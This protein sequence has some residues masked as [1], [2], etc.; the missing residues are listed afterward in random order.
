MA[1]LTGREKFGF[2]LFQGKALLWPAHWLG[3]SPVAA[4]FQLALPKCAYALL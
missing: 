4:T 3:D 1:A 2:L